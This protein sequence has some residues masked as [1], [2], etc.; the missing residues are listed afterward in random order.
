MYNVQ[1]VIIHV[2]NRKE[3]GVEF[4]FVFT[5]SIKH[6]YVLFEFLQVLTGL[7]MQLCSLWGKDEATSNINGGRPPNFSVYLEAI[8]TF[9]RHPSLSVAHYANAL[10]TAFFKHDLISKDPVFL[11][12]VP[13]WVEA[14]APK[15]V[16]VIRAT[17]SKL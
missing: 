12:F 11:N 1:C 13:K 9:S 10:W 17:I 6:L 3:Y 8:V 14:T 5:F 16:K 15:I 7:G 4:I 2:I